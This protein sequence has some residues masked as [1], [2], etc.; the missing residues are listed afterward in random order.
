MATDTPHVLDRKRGVSEVVCALCAT[1]QKPSATCSACGVLFGE[2]SCLACNFFDDDLSKGHFH[3][4]A[5]GICR[6][7]GRDNFFHC[8]TCNACYTV[9]IQGNHTCV[10][11]S[12]AGNCPV[13]CDALFDSLTGVIV[14]RCGHTIHRAC[15]DEL[16]EHGS[17]QCPSCSRSLVPNEHMQARWDVLDAAVAQTPMPTELASSTVMI[18]CNDC[19]KRCTTNFHVLGHK[20]SACGSYNTRRV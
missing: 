11:D 10:S 5:C 17:Y 19:N 4:D 6:V 20:C 2:Y 3:C 12:M 15:L 9:K 7:G 13:C 8:S 14:L 16:I 1:R 18:M